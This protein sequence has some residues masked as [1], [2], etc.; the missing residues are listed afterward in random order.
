MKGVSRRGLR[1]SDDTVGRSRGTSALQRS[2]NRSRLPRCTATSPSSAARATI[3]P[4]TA[5]QLQHAPLAAFAQWNEAAMEAL[6]SDDGDSSRRILS[7]LLPV[8]EARLHAMEC[9]P[10]AHTSAAAV[11]SW[12]LVH[13]LTLNNYGCQLRRDGRTDE[14]LRQLLRA[15]QVETP[16]FG[17]PSCSTMLNLSAVLLSTGAVEEA[18]SIS[19]ECVMAAQ[20]HEP[21][22]FITALHNLAV[23]LGQQTSERERK[24]ALPTMLQALREAQ[25]VLG[26][27]HPTTLMLKEKCGLTYT[28]ISQSSG[29]DGGKRAHASVSAMRSTS[30]SAAAKSILPAQL[31]ALEKARAALH[32]LDFG[33]PAHPPSIMH[34]VADFDASESA[35]SG[36]AKGTEE[37]CAVSVSATPLNES[38]RSEHSEADAAQEEEHLNCSR[39]QRSESSHSAVSANGVGVA[40]VPMTPGETASSPAISTPSRQSS[41]GANIDRL[42]L[43]SA[44]LSVT[45]CS[46]GST[47]IEAVMQ[48][49][50]QAAALVVSGSVPHVVGPVGPIGSLYKW[51]TAKGGS[52]PSFLRFSVP[53]PPSVA[54]KASPPLRKI[55]PP[56][57][58]ARLR[59]ASNA[60]VERRRRTLLQATVPQSGSEA[61]D[62]S[63]LEDTNTSTRIATIPTGGARKAID[64]G[65]KS[66]AAAG[67]PALVPFAVQRSL[68]GSTGPLH[69]GRMVHLE[70]ERQ[71]ERAFRARMEAE[72]KA[73]EAEEAFHR[74]IED[75]HCRTRNRAAVT[76]Q[77][78]WQQWWGSKGR[79]RRLVQQQRLEELQRRRRERLLLGAVAGK[80]LN[81]GK[82]TVPPPSSQQHGHAGGY[83]VPAVVLRCVKKWLLTTICVRYLAKSHCRPVVTRLHE[84]DVRRC[85]CRI[86][87]LWRGVAVRRRQTQEQLQRLSIEDAHA[88]VL[89]A[90]HRLRAEAELRDYSALVLQ[91]A[92][93]SHCA[94][95]RRRRLYLDQHNGPATAIQR[96]L[97]ATLAD[98]R[99]RGVDTRTVRKRNAAALT[100]QRLW[101]GYLGRVTFRMRELRLRM[102]RVSS[103][104]HALV[105][106]VVAEGPLTAIECCKGKGARYISAQAI[107]ALA[108][109]AVKGTEKPLPAAQADSSTVDKAALVLKRES[110]ST[111]AYE[112]GCLQRSS[113]VQQLRDEERD[114][115]H[116][117]LYVEAVATKERQAWEESLRLR[118]TE[119]LRRRIAMDVQIGEE[120]RAFTERRAALAI[121][122]AYRHWR[123]MRHDPGRDTTMLFYARGRYQ[124]RELAFLAERKRW[125]LEVERGTAIYS[126][127]AATMREERAKAAEELD[128]IENGDAT[129]SRTRSPKEITGVTRQAAMLFPLGVERRARDQRRRE[130]EALQR[131]DEILVALTYPHDMAHVREGPKECAVRIGTTYEHPYYIPYV[132]EEHRR[133]LGID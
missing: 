124:Q 131:R 93:R 20:D 121:Q 36:S 116:I 112:A 122:R 96:W 73:A 37:V 85:S 127:S 13:A 38:T 57:V 60:S 100:I 45:Q 63:S 56:A 119:V 115:Y 81:C 24:A 34:A 101:R 44:N 21:I 30:G 39:P 58:S 7:V 6:R 35:Q 55:G 82:A 10:S 51:H 64:Q 59:S 84:E 46:V 118:P 98:Q 129:T 47:P 22:L 86:Q 16:V 71:E 17:K 31:A 103:G 88:G 120:Q 128:L 99:R 74:A 4:P 5:R 65:E 95:Q 113:E 52:G 79:S 108:P 18:L 110:A 3:V 90:A 126:D 67:T 102:D 72:K 66:G 114:R 29:A 83:V 77:H 25:S 53:P 132:N 48:E 109:D 62:G 49:P 105:A 28:W 80:K 125:R 78:V 12:R 33:E 41:G 42:C 107:T 133:T 11:D 2:H 19:K 32:T 75:L 89:S 91:M 104:S 111:E 69:S 87:A 9:K 43:D 94:R 15:K 23:A 54:K 40:P 1:G 117:G 76:I 26:E 92:Y 97:R 14:A 106:R 70:A 130:Q 27:Q 50:F 123:R 61:S 8:L 68:F